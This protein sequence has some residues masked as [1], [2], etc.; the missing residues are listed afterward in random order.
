M[1]EFIHYFLHLVFPFF[2]A[3]IFF[4]K[5][6][7]KAYLTMLA[8]MLVD[9]D[10]FLAD[11]IFQANRCS[12]GFHPFHSFYIIPLYFLLILFPKPFRWIGIGLSLHM[13]TD[14]N[15]CMF[16]YTQCPSCQEG[17]P[18]YEILHRIAEILRI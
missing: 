3:W 15:D 17:A 13:L 9:L 12:V 7:K 8:T 1:Q 18:A 14:L 16:M 2:I 10:H 5:D 6:W 11:P 4:R